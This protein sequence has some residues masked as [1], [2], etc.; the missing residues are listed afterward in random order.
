[1]TKVLLQ[2]KSQQTSDCFPQE[3]NKK[4]NPIC[5]LLISIGLLPTHHV[6]N[7]KSLRKVSY[8]DYCKDQCEPYEMHGE[9]LPTMHNYYWCNL[10]C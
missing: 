10:S 4:R 8:L 2:T 6:Y 7:W 1:M 3:Q 9:T 5:K